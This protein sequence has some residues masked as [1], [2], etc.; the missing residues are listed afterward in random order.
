MK[1][2][3]FNWQILLG[4]LLSLFAFISYPVIFSQWPVT[5]DFPWANIVL[6]VLAAAL[7]FVGLRRAFSSERG[8]LSKIAASSLTVVSGFALAMFIFIAFVMAT[9]L[10][11]SAGAPQVG[12]RA[13]DLT[14]TDSGGK[15]VALS[16]LLADKKGV[17]LVFYR[18][19]W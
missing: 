17:L 2:S 7:I 12:Q 11:R 19:Y 15:Q 14:L 1:T 3:G 4:S 8:T 5:R 10:P 18:G 13:P 16:Q 9:W 6:F